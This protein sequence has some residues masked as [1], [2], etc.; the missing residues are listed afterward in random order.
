MPFR[1]R[2][3]SCPRCRVELDRIAADD[4][5]RCAGCDGVVLNAGTLV[6]ELLA[7]DPSLR[8]GIRIRDIHTI[9]RRTDE[10]LPCAVCG[11]AMEPV[12][13]GGVAIDRCRADGVLWFDVG[14]LEEVLSR[15]AEQR[16]DRSVGLLRRLF[17]LARP[18]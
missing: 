8:D 6:A 10:E 7:V 14:E 15:T 12:F 4:R 3:P 1:D 16:D 11:G 5:F 18:R 9:G 13:L 2:P 17:G